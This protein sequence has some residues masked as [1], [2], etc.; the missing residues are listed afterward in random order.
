MGIKKFFKTKPP[1]EEEINTKIRDQMNE[2][3]IPIKSQKQK[4]QLF[5]AYS[6]FANDKSEKKNICT[7]GV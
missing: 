7:K 3:G 5:Q 2:N 4:P 6:K 1:S